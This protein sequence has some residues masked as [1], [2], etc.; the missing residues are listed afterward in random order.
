MRLFLKS[1][2]KQRRDHWEQT[3]LEGGPNQTGNPHRGH[4]GKG[5]VFEQLPCAMRPM[6][7][8][9]C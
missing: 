4:F 6:D 7:T 5:Q 8:T 2:V 3:S 1:R 9:T